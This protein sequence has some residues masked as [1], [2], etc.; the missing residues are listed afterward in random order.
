[1]GP[2]YWPPQKFGQH[3]PFTDFRVARGGFERF[4][5]APDIHVLR[6]GHE[7]RYCSGFVHFADAGAPAGFGGVVGAGPFEDVEV[8]T[9]EGDGGGGPGRFG[10]EDGLDGSFGGDFEDEAAAGGG[11]IDGAVG[12]D[13][14]ALEAGEAVGRR[15]GI[16]IFEVGA[17]DE[18]FDGTVLCD[19]EDADGGGDVECAVRAGGETGDASALAGQFFFEFRGDGGDGAVA[20]YTADGVG[21]GRAA[22]HVK[23]L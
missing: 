8:V 2:G 10:F 6:D 9:V 4:L 23:W 13:V 18:C 20:R 17:F 21:A 5:S 15:V 14:H 7:R 19:F 11:G 22:I 16:A 3:G 1:M 12:G